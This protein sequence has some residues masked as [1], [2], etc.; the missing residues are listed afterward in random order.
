MALQLRFFCAKS[1]IDQPGNFLVTD[2]LSLPRN[3]SPE[4]DKL[5]IAVVV[6]AIV[7][8][9]DTYRLMIHPILINALEAAQEAGNEPPVELSPVDQAAIQICYGHVV[10]KIGNFLGDSNRYQTAAITYK[11]AIENIE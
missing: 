6:A 5:L 10:S 7:P 11:G 9:T 2:C 1:E 3:F 4:Y 8:K